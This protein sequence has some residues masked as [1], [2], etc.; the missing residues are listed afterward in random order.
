MTPAPG[1]AQVLWFL[2]ISITAVGLSY[3]TQALPPAW[4]SPEL[5]ASTE[6]NGKGL[7]HDSL[8]AVL[9]NDRNDQLHR[10]GLMNG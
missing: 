7:K 8:Q 1:K 4:P 3:R 2:L 10:D 5:R 9:V 6:K